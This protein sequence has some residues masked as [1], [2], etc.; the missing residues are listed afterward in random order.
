MPHT[1]VIDDSLKGEQELLARAHLHLKG[2]LD[3][4]ENKLEEDAVAALYDAISSAMQRF[5][6]PGV[7][8]QTLIIKE[9][10]DISEDMTLFNVLRRTGIIDNSV[11][12]DDFT[13][14][15][16]VLDDALEY[17]L[18]NFNRGKFIETTNRLLMQLHVIP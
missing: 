6:Y 7:S 2:G 9:G 15:E 18:S 17:R 10:E 12:E 1:G 11:S 4:L 16:T 14:I 3:R 5:T 8:N 13:Y